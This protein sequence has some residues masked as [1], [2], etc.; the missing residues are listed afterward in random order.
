[1]KPHRLR[2][3]LIF[4][5]SVLSFSPMI[6]HAETVKI[7]TL[8]K[9]HCDADDFNSHIFSVSAT[10][11]E[12]PKCVF[13]SLRKSADGNDLE[14]ETEAKMNVDGKLVFLVRKDKSHPSEFVSKDGLINVKLDVR[15]TNTS[16]VEGEDKCCGSD[17]AGT[18]SIRTEKGQSSIRVEYYR[19]G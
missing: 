19:G 5:L 4:I 2:C 17:F 18:L 11:G 6:S 16:C 8:S 3:F 10:K 12:E 15:E 14:Y 7:G 1:M 9:K 13:T